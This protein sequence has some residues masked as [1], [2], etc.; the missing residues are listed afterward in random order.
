MITSTRRTVSLIKLKWLLVHCKPTILSNFCVPIWQNCNIV[1]Q[2]VRGS[3]YNEPKGQCPNRHAVDYI[4]G[5][6]N[7]N[8]DDNDD[9]ADEDVNGYDYVDGDDDDGFETYNGD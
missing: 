3:S 5:L 6:T 9:D 8:D 1:Q 7:S 4:C 2:D